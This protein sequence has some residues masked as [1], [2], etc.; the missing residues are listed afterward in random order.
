MNAGET[1]VDAYPLAWPAG[2]PRATSRVWGQF[3]G[4]IDAARWELLKEIDLLVLG[5]D[6]RLYTVRQ[7]VVISTN[8]PLRKDGELHAGSPEPADP[9]VAVYFTRNKKPVCLACDKYDRVWKNIRALAKT[10]EALR[11]IERWGSTQLLDRAFTGFAALPER[12]GPDVWELLGLA[13]DADEAAIL[14]AYRERAQTAHPDKGGTHEA[15][16]ALTKCKDI[17]LATVRSRKAGA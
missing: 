7:H 3:K 14:K 15:F 16:D 10:I 8:K 12:T 6:T 1:Q 9:G 5:P 13:P 2:W 4:T 17:A 11:G